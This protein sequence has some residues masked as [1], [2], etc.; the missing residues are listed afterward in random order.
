MLSIDNIAEYKSVWEQVEKLPA[1]LPLRRRASFPEYLSIEEIS[2]LLYEFSDE[3]KICLCMLNRAI[4]KGELKARAVI[5]THEPADPLGVI[6]SLH[7]HIKIIENQFRVFQQDVITVLEKNIKELENDIEDTHNALLSL[8]Q[9]ELSKSND[10]NT[11]HNHQVN[12]RR[13]ANKRLRNAKSR[14]PIRS[15]TSI[16]YDIDKRQINI[17]IIHKDDM[18]LWLKQNNEWPLKDDT[19][20]SRWFSK[21]DRKQDK[22]LVNVIREDILKMVAEDL[23]A[24][25]KDPLAFPGIVADVFELCKEKSIA[26]YGKSHAFTQFETWRNGFWNRR[27]QPNHKGIIELADS[28][29]FSQKS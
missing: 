26:V 2:G 15:G 5:A 11:D 19:H 8:L 18:K 7:S 25:G 24:D 27:K 22:P 16:G 1:G 4:S 14:M 17:K 23:K 13:R 10:V 6:R 20:L 12:V 9:S 3:E 29:S 28:R 21:K